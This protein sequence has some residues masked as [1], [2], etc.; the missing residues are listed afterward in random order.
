MLTVNYDDLT[1]LW[2]LHQ[3]LFDFPRLDAVSADFDLIISTAE[4]YQFSRCI[5][6]GEIAGL[7]HPLA[8]IEWI[9]YEF[10]LSHCFLVKISLGN[11][12]PSDIDFTGCARRY[13]LQACIQY[14]NL[15]VP[16][17]YADWNGPFL[18]SLHIFINHTSDNRLGR[19]V[20]VKDADLSAR[21][22]NNA[23][24]ERILKILSTHDQLLY[25]RMTQVHL[26]DQ[27]QV[28]GCQLNDAVLIILNNIADQQGF[29]RSAV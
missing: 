18:F 27:L 1:D 7:V 14:I 22:T 5:A 9:R 23:C 13:G 26:L 29:I 8:G 12:D 15:H 6:A 28:T 10:L 3:H 4:I 20:L 17:R 21:L 19:A 16:C 24:C 11:S 2:K 25:S